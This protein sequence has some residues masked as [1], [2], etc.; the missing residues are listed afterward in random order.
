[1]PVIGG[2][3]VDLTDLIGPRP[4]PT[5]YGTDK[6]GVPNKAP[7]GEIPKDLTTEEI[8][9]IKLAALETS[10][11]GVDV[12]RGGKDYT[13]IADRIGSWFST[14]TCIPGRQTTNGN[15]VI[16]TLINLGHIGRR[17]QIDVT[18][19]GTSPV[20]IGKMYEMDIVPMVMSGKSYAKERA[21]RLGFISLRAEWWWKF[22]EDLDPSFGSDIALPPDSDLLADLTSPKWSMSI[23]GIQVEQ[24]E[25]VK[26]RLG[27]S[28]DKGDAVVYSHAIPHLVAEAYL[29]YVKEQAQTEQTLREEEEKRRK[30]PLNQQA[31]A[32]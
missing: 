13:I 23:R 11:V 2:S 30:G 32:V 9:K 24:K 7:D 5:S 15:Q 16:Q 27:R 12:S 28:P 20:D 31:T 21:G 14:L 19:V 26:A 25:H 22:R 10:A 29:K 1:M 17:I 4:R 6:D 8:V 18:G 3:G